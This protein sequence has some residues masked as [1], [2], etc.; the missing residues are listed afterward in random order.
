MEEVDKGW[1]MIM[2]GVSGWMLLL[3]LAHTGSP[4]KRGCSSRVQLGR[5]KNSTDLSVT[6]WQIWWG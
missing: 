2:I 5:Y 6:L 3:V 4:G 1:L